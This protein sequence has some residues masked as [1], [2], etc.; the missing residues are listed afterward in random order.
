M[1]L[2]KPDAVVTI[3]SDEGKREEKVT[4]AKSGTDGY[5]SRE[6]EPGVAKVDASS[7]DNIVKSLEALK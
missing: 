3:K 5:A 7:I 6:G 4:F 2:D 1:G